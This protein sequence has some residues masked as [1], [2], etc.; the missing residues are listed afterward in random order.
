MTSSG[1]IDIKG[2]RF[3]YGRGPRVLDIEQ[4][5]VATGE[6]VMLTGASGSG[7]STLLGLVAGV[8]AGG[9]GR[10]EVL[11]QDMI[12]ASLR[13]RDRLRAD[14]MGY[15]FQNF[16]LV[17]YLS[18]LDNVTLPCRMSAHRAGKLE[19]PMRESALALVSALGLPEGAHRR[20]VT[21]LSVGQQQRVAA[22]RA[23][24]GAPDLIIADEPTSSLDEDSK[25]DFL[26]LLLAQ[27]DV[28][29]AAVLFV[30]HDHRLGSHFDR[31]VDLAAINAAS[32]EV[33]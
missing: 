26:R 28:A 17:P 16:N 23:L 6:R 12:A 33:A 31:T 25:N 8:L 15:I 22:A 13:A 20:A 11:G 27:A 1:A 14:Y 10:L 30:T 18:V 2:L 4:F 19:R 7:K 21:E 9:S 5:R 32:R 29:E 24:M 3:G